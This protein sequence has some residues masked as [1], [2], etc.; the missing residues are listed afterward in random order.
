[1]LNMK[2]SINTALVCLMSFLLAG[3]GGASIESGGSA[4]TGISVPSGGVANATLSF[5]RLTFG[6]ESFSAAIQ[7]VYL[8][9]T[10]FSAD[11]G[12]DSGL[13]GKSVWIGIIDDFRTQQDA[14]FRFPALLRQKS[15]KTKASEGTSTSNTSTT[16]TCAVPHEWSI[17]WTHGELVEQIAGGVL[18]EQLR[19]VSLNVPTVSTNA[20]CAATFY[21]KS[22]ASEAL[23]KF[24]SVTG[25]AAGASMQRY[26]VVLGETADN[27][28]QLFTI[29]GH[30]I[31]ALEDVEHRI[32]VVNLSLGSEI[33]PS[34]S[35][36]QK[37]LADAL[38]TYPVN[39][40][41]DTVISVAAGNSGLSCNKENLVGCNLVAVAMAAQDNT[42]GSAIVVGALTGT[43]RA[44]RI[45]TYSNFPGYLK[46][47][48][49]WASGDSITFPSNGT[50]W[51]VGT[52]FA[53]PR[54]AGAAALL[55]QK[56]P[57]LSS[58]QIADLLLDSANRDMDNDGVADFEGAS[59][60]WGR[61][62]LDLNAALRLAAL[63]H[64]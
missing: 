47:R 61:G 10:K 3:C 37:I 57:H 33:Q 1:V 59:F 17:K 31:H 13:T 21:G 51:A 28:L 45:A 16:S 43:G 46:D 49:L 5:P 29:L 11:E 41:V 34:D 20:E 58:V 40:M 55:R 54:V 60:T 25:V 6:L 26:P 35:S 15:T 22:P 30:L 2:S 8:G 7:S 44:Q 39:A 53:T 18:P 19:P 14:V 50:N 48:F 9:P 52:S 38:A 27:K 63:R 24:S 32:G 4:D 56:Y 23:L 64:G 42:K 62:K 36:R 12:A